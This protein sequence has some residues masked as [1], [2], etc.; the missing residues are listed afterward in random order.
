MGDKISQLPA[1]TTVD[2][3]ELVPIVQGGATK[4]VTGTILRSP[5]GSA[6]GDLGGSYP[7]PTLAAIT[8]AQA[9]V[10]S[11]SAIPVVSIDAKGRVVALST[12]ANPALTTNQIVGLSTAAGAALTTTALAGLSTFAARAD[13]THQL[14]TAGQV[15]A[16][17]ATAAAGGDLVGNY[18]N[19]SLAAITT[20]QSN[21]G[22]GTSVPVLS[23][24]A[25]GRVTALGTT[26][27]SSSAGGTVTSITAGTGLSGGTI[28]SSGT[29]DIAAVTTAQSNVGS[30]TQIPVLSIN[31]QG[32]VT[33]LSSVAVSGSSAA[34][35]TA[36]PAALATAPYAGLSTEASRS[37]HQHPFPTAAQVGALGAT[38]AATGDLTGNYPAPTLVAITTAQT[39]VGSATAIPVIST[40]AKGRVTALSTVAFAALTTNQIA[41]LSTSAPAALATSALVGLS[42][43]AARADHQHVFPTLGQLGAQAALTTSA[44]LALSLGGTGAT[45]AAGAASNLGALTTNQIA[46]LST[47]AGAALTT[48]AIAGL[49]TFAARADHTHVFPTAANVGA[50]GAT[51]AAGGDLTGNYPNPTLAAITTAQSNVGSSTLIPILSIDAKGRVT[52][53]SSVASSGATALSTFRNRIINGDMLIDQRNG[54]VASANTINGYFLDRWQVVQATT[55]GKL[56]AQQNAGPLTPPLGFS[57][58]LGVTSQS[59]YAITA[60]DYYL[61]H[62]PIEGQNIRDFGWGSANAVSIT[63]SFWVYS[64]LTGTF[65]GAI[66]NSTGSRTYGF[67]YSIAASNQWTQISITIPG[68]TTGTW[69]TTNGVGM[70]V[71][72]GLGVG[73]NYTVPSGS[74]TNTASVRFSASGVSVVG[75]AGATFY[76]TGVQLEKGSTASSFELLPYTTTI[77]LCQRYYDTTTMWVPAAGDPR[78]IFYK[79]SMRSN[80]TIGGGGTGFAATNQTVNGSSVTQTTAGNQTLTLLSEL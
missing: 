26:P 61:I 68:E 25:K 12:V 9:G 22:S 7:N 48:T 24:D 69:L 11:Q 47:E 52:A 39:N 2:G 78:Q 54:G 55:T 65:G 72:F 13:H 3:T 35:S 70:Y 5:T 40:D 28:T 50:L 51:A 76:I 46:G 33:A 75:T 16:L 57:K 6:G 36:A 38:A 58:Y 74:W 67:N 53:L 27:I 73:S 60:S 15:G 23:I 20:A 62:Q 49:S 79:T 37:D 29:I 18:P 71:Y 31:A 17:G 63:L 4:K 59:S 10:G 1:A 32:Q 19:P 41:G 30:G 43:F 14:P 8:T 80:P 77:G 56:V 42:T 21:V 34:L 66:G 45:T 44:P 64:F